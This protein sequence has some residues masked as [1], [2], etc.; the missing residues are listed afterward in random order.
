M[1]RLHHKLSWNFN[2]N[3]YRSNI[4]TYTHTHTYIHRHSHTHIPTHTHLHMHIRKYMH[5]YFYS[6]FENIQWRLIR[7]T[8]NQYMIDAQK[9]SSNLPFSVYL[10]LKLLILPRLFPSVQNQARFFHSKVLPS[11]SGN[12]I[13]NSKSGLFWHLC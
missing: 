7:K 8:C 12:D 6:N 3:L 5:I 9:L 2:A 10:Y 11:Y 4:S 13:T 1:P